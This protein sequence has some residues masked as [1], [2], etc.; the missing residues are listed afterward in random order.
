MCSKSTFINAN[1][2]FA[3]WGF[4]QRA[5]WYLIFLPNHTSCTMFWP[6]HSS[7]LMGIGTLL[8]LLLPCLSDHAQIAKN[9]AN[10]WRSFHGNWQWVYHCLGR[11]WIVL[12]GQAKYHLDPEKC[13]WKVNS[14]S[15]PFWAG[16]TLI[17]R[18]G[19]LTK[20]TPCL[21]RLYTD[22]H[23]VMIST[24]PI[25]NNAHRMR[26]VFGGCEQRSQRFKL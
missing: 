22:L 21:T 11:L 12:C 26:I 4:S 3:Y 13:Q 2:I 23:N 14:S 1:V 8:Q 15:E 25:Y 6:N 9:C 7:Y 18:T 17:F 24:A 19:S 20:D 16:F 5:N 10:K